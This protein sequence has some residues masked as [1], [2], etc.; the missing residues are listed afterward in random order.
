M[1]VAGVAF[2]VGDSFAIDVPSCLPARCCLFVSCSFEDHK[3]RG[4]PGVVRRGGFEFF[5]RVGI[6]KRH[7]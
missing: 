7:G 4:N 1:V 3:R 6:P 2:C 5:V